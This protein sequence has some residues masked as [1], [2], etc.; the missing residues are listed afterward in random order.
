MKNVLVVANFNAGRKQAIK[1]KKRI[2][3]FLFKN[4]Q[5]FKFCR[6]EDLDKQDFDSID[7]LIVIG[8]DG[9]LN[10]VL[11]YA[12]GRTIG[13]IPCGTAN[14][15][16]AKLGISEN[17]NSALKIIKNGNVKEIDLLDVNGSPC[18]LRCG[19]GYDS[20]IICH[21]P[22]SLKNKFGYFAYFVAGILYGFRL[23]KKTYQISY[24]NNS[25]QINASCIIVANSANMF[26]NIVNVGNSELD[27]EKFEI[28]ILKVLNPVLF[29][30]EFLKIILNI[31]LNT[32]YAYFLKCDNFEINSPYLNF[33]ID[34]ERAKLDKKLV[35]KISENKIKIYC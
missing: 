19:F 35:F 10:S 12:G 7:T 32:S 16:A 21:T 18:I 34:G 6:V 17:L 24:D 3:N 30:M 28:F 15:V 8:G 1:Y 26:K 25:G 23:K 27:D 4:A 13:I 14:L 2:I 5:T 20:N 22:Q 33:H 11:P 9:T 31:K 29:F